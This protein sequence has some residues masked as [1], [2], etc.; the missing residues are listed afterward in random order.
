MVLPSAKV[1]IFVFSMKRKRSLINMLN[2]NGPKIES[3][4]TP[5]TISNHVVNNHKLRINPSGL[6]LQNHLCLVLPAMV[7]IA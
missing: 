2:N 6:F 7:A 5:L 1:Q 3:C 4:G